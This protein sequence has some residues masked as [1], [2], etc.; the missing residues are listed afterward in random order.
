MKFRM[1]FSQLWAGAVGFSVARLEFF[2][3]EFFHTKQHFR[4]TLIPGKSRGNSPKVHCVNYLYG[5]GVKR[6]KILKKFSTSL[7]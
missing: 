5:K 6:W 1:K 2:L 3:A 7:T 4:T